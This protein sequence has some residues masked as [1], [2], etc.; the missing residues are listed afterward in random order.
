MKV[1]LKTL[2]DITTPGGTVKADRVIEV[3]EKTARSMIEGGLAR[4]DKPRRRKKTKKK[5]D[6]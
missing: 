6:S 5:G 3:N 2:K 1:K 4:A